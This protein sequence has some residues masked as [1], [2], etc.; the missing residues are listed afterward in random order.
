MRT[1]STFLYKNE[2]KAR[3]KVMRK[4]G[5]IA[6]VYIE[7]CYESYEQYGA[8]TDVLWHTLPIAERLVE[9]NFKSF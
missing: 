8:E 2:K 1:I 5:S 4:G 7:P 3:V 9:T 6:T